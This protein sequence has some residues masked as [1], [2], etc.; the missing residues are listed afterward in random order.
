[1]AAVSIKKYKNINQA[2]NVNKKIKKIFYPNTKNKNYYSKKYHTYIKLRETL[3]K[4]W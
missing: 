2:V 4:I 1:M 3:S